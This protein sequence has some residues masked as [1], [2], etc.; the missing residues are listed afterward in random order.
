MREESRNVQQ[1]YDIKKCDY[2]TK[3][4]KHRNRSKIS[5]KAEHVKRYIAKTDYP[6]N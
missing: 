2:T 4:K 3:N 1:L 5:R 6:E